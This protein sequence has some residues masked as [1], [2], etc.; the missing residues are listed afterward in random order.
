M[1]GKIVYFSCD[2]DIGIFMIQY[3][4]NISFK[5]LMRLVTNQN[6][7]MQKTWKMNETLACGYSFESTQRELSNEYQHDRIKM[8]FLN[9]CVLVLLTKVASALD[10]GLSKVCNYSLGCLFQ[11]TLQDW[12]VLYGIDS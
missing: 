10:L 6:K 8:F 5:T 9:L 3:D 11:L 1:G 12:M 4:I 2:C 7:K